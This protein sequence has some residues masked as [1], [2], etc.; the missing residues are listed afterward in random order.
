MPP[1]VKPSS[2]TTAVFGPESVVRIASAA[3][4]PPAA[5]SASA[6]P[7]TPASN[8]SIGSRGPIVDQDALIAALKEKRIAGAGIDV[9][10]VEPLPKD[11]PILSAPN[12]VLTPHLG[13]V[14]EENYRVYYRSTVENIHAYL[15]GKPIRVITP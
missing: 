5:E 12:T 15:A 14:T 3:S 1:T 9:Y 11:H 2:S 4:A 13:Y 8:D 10:D 7:S 6:A